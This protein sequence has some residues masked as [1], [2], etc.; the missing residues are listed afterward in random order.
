MSS[1]SS[2]QTFDQLSA[3]LQAARD[4]AS[5]RT[6]AE[7]ARLDA[8]VAALGGAVRWDH[9]AFEKAIAAGT[10]DAQATFDAAI[11]SNEKRLMQWALRD[12]AACAKA[13]IAKGDRESAVEFM[14]KLREVGREKQRLLGR[15]LGEYGVP[16][17]AWL[18]FARVM[19]NVRPDAMAAFAASDA[20][21][22]VRGTPQAVD[23]VIRAATHPEQAG[24]ALEALKH[25]EAV[26]SRI[27]A[28]TPGAAITD[29]IC[30]RWDLC[31]SGKSPGARE[32]A[33]REL[34]DAKQ[35]ADVASWEATRDRA[36]SVRAGDVSASRGLS[37]AELDS[38]LKLGAE[39]FGPIAANV[40]ALSPWH[41]HSDGGA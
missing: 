20:L 38:I 7:R 1:A 8:A 32:Q 19:I 3:T 34:A 28:S 22:S 35:R 4:A 36:R 21:S 40:R 23:R 13:F 14:A 29:E 15:E 12:L 16:G 2:P 9:V 18:A 11:A 6:A 17:E 5:E 31:C 30:A 27:A 25:L 41:K 26:C 33:L 37:P 39:V 24:E 10:A